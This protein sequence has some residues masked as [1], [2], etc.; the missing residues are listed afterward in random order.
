MQLH[1]VVTTKMFP[2]PAA[3]K[4]LA[5]FGDIFLHTD[6]AAFATVG[7]KHMVVEGP[8]KAISAWLA[9]FDGVWV[10]KGQPAQQE[11]EVLHIKRE[12][13]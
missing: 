4:V 1:L 11:F 3:I 2:I 13:A 7:G 8:S 10:G 12:I 6:E 5:D 9:P